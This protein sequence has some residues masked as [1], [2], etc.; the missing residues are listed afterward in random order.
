[1]NLTL[2]GHEEVFVIGD[3]AASSDARGAALPG[4]APVAKQQGAY[5]ARRIR[6]RVAGRPGL[7]PFRYRNFGSMATIGRKLAVADFGW[8][9]VS[10]LLGWF[11]WSGLHILTLIGFRNRMVVALDW[12]W[13]YLTY[14]RGARLITGPLPEDLATLPEAQPQPRR[15][16]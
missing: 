8:L 15:V 5:V 12:L 13:A 9:R 6:A 14:Q 16:A 4:V 1:A 3:T 11:L 2:P 10:G 7:R